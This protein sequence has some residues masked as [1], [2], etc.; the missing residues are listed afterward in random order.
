MIKDLNRYER[1]YLEKI[2]GL[3]QLKSFI[4]TDD[5]TD[6]LIINAAKDKNS[7]AYKYFEDN[8]EGPD[9]KSS[10]QE[11]NA[12]WHT[13]SDSKDK[14][15]PFYL[16]QER[17][18]M[19]NRSKAVL[20]YLRNNGYDY[21]IARDRNDGQITAK[22]TGKNLEMRLLDTDSNAM[23]GGTRVYRDGDVVR[24][25]QNKGENY[26]VTADM[27]VDLLKYSMGEPVLRKQ[28]VTNSAYDIDRTPAKA[29]RS[30]N[31][32]AGSFDFNGKDS[33]TYYTTNNTF[34]TLYMQAPPMAATADR[35]RWDGRIEIMVETPATGGKT[36]PRTFDADTAESFIEDSREA[37]INNLTG[38]LKL[39]A[40]DAL[41]RSK[42]NG[43]YEGMPEFSLDNE[44]ITNMQENYYR[45]RLKI[46]R[47]HSGDEQ[48]IRLGE[49]NAA[50]KKNIEATFGDADLR[51][52]N[53][54]N[55]ATFMNN[56]NTI[57]NE[58]DLLSALKT[59]QKTKH[60]TGQD[61]SYEITES[62]PDDF[63][64]NNF[65]N[66]LVEYNSDTARNI[67][68][69]SKNFKELPE[70]WQK[71][72]NTV[73]TSLE[74][75]GI[76]PQSIAVDDQGVIHYEGDYRRGIKN[77]KTEKVIGNIGQVFEPDSRKL[78]EKGEP[79]LKEGLIETK[80]ASGNNYYIAPGY[81]A[82]VVPPTDNDDKRTYVE[83]TRCRGYMQ[84]MTSNI[85]Q[86]INNDIIS[87]A[88]QKNDT[89]IVTLDNA[90]ALNNTYKHLYDE[91]LPLDFEEKMAQTGKD[92]DMIKAIIQTELGT[93]RYDSV[94][95]T[96]TNMLA[97]A[98]VINDE[99]DDPHKKYESK[100]GT[101]DLIADNT[102]AVLAKMD[103][104]A[105][106]H[107]FDKMATGTGT[108]QGIKVYLTSDAKV[109]D[110]GSITPGKSTKCPLMEH[111]DFRYAEYNSRDRVVMS[112]SNA[113]TQSSTARNIGTAHMSLGGFTQDDAFVIS[114]S[115]AEENVIRGKSGE[116][117]PLTIGDK[118]CD[119]SGNKGV[120]SYIGDPN[121]DE[122]YYKHTEITDNMSDDE[123]KKVQRD[124]DA[125]D[126]YKRIDDLFKANSDLQVIGAPYTPPSRFNGG[127]AR[128][129]IESQSWAKESG[130]ET[131]LN[132][133]GKAYP[134]SIGYVN[135]IV[136]D[137]P[138][139]EKTHNYRNKF[140]E[141]EESENSES[142]EEVDSTESI[143][144]R[145]SSGQ[146][147]GALAEL[148]AYDVIREIYSQNTE[149]TIKA[150]E[151]IIPMGYDISQTG[152][153]HKGYEPH[154]TG[155]DENNQPVYEVRQEIS[156][157]EAFNRCQSEIKS[158]M[159][160]NNKSFKQEFIDSL[161]AE[162]GFMK[163][164]FPIKMASGE[165][166]PA[167]KDENGNE[168]N[169]YLL[170]VMA[171]K[172][173]SNRETV[174]NRLT[175]HEY[176]ADYNR[177]WMA[178]GKYLNEKYNRQDDA[179]AMECMR[180]VQR[181]YDSM[182]ASIEDRYLD[183]KHNVWKDDVMRKQL[184]NTAT[185]VISP[186]PTLDL[187][188]IRMTAIMA[189][190]LGIDKDKDKQAVVWRD[191]VLSGGGVRMFDVQVIETR[192]DHA[193]YDPK[194]PMNG[195]VGI[196]MNPSSA[197]SFE[198]D[199]DGDS[200]GLYG[201]QTTK[202]K[203]NARETLSM[204]AN[205]L[206]KE[207]VV[208]GGD[209]KEIHPAYFQDGLDV[210]AG[211]YT[212]ESIGNRMNDAVRLANT[213]KDGTQKQEAFDK[214][215]DAM[216][217]A[218]KA[219]FG[220][221]IINYS[222]SKSYFE[223]LIPMT[224]SGAKGS[225]SK[226]ETYGKYFGA[227]VT[228]SDEGKLQDNFADKGKP[229][230]TDDE[231]QAAFSATHA[232]AVL[233]G[234]AGKSLQHGIMAGKNAP[235]GD[236]EVTYAAAAN[237]LTHPV[238]QSTMQLKHDDAETITRKINLISNI[239]PALWSGKMVEKS[240]DK[241]WQVKQDM[242]GK[243][244]NGFPTD[245]I[246]TPEEWKKSFNDFYT[247]KAGLGV[248]KPNPE[249]VD[250]MAKLLTRDGRIF[251]FDPQRKSMP[252]EK[253]LDSL[254][255]EASLE[256]LDRFAK[257]KRNLFEGSINELMAP[258][259]IADNIEI[260]KG[261]SDKTMKPL[262]AK[263]TQA[264]VSNAP[265]VD[266]VAVALKNMP[267]NE[268]K[269]ISPVK[270]EWERS[271]GSVAHR[272][273]KSLT[274]NQF[275]QT[276]MHLA[277]LSLQYKDEGSLTGDKAKAEMTRID[278][279]FYSNVQKQMKE[280]K[281]LSD[282]KKREYNNNIAQRTADYREL[283]AFSDAKHILREQQKVQVD[284]M[285]ATLDERTAKQQA[286]AFKPVM[287][288]NVE[289]KPAQTSD[290]QSM[291]TNKSKYDATKPYGG[292]EK[293][294]FHKAAQEVAHDIN[295]P[296]DDC[297]VIRDMMRHEKKISLLSHKNLDDPTFIA[298]YAQAETNN[299][300]DKSGKL[301]LTP[302]CKAYNFY[303]KQMQQTAE[304]TDNLS[305]GRMLYEKAMMTSNVKKMSEQESEF[306]RG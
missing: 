208:P 100:K 50:F 134:G 291:D 166:T 275:K 225:P 126:A 270:D 181:N 216:H 252:N 95:K 120:I 153:L 268:V 56:E 209:N 29:D 9:I 84:E 279:E 81:T 116:L 160:L 274:D 122:S 283:S 138:V 21:N 74:S 88:K 295:A 89:G 117:R 188:Q 236:N 99:A 249:Y 24:F 101:Y 52:I 44:F 127:T 255:Y 213:A 97:E 224:L 108:N 215:N 6:E 159:T 205:F 266:A 140:S 79:N 267:A 111:S 49:H 263:D 20:S 129:M 53:P 106:E 185:A 143:G 260:S 33:K 115:F 41:A 86:T 83:R 107:Y 151:L 214:F 92:K 233:T 229:F 228:I 93:V 150:R 130:K 211:K 161:S 125:K 201:L 22:L 288:A 64:L 222:D 31:E 257:Q 265:S 18:A 303:K 112:V 109:N 298:F 77:N 302:A 2:S 218:H 11:L 182:A 250:Q 269:I 226:L 306:Q 51:T 148:G 139:D 70:F 144:G 37:A 38:R 26:H 75:A 272:N 162:G 119:H 105:L 27:A 96:G 133:D 230:V 23:Y 40:V 17:W 3:S 171:G 55:V 219:A 251:G 76:N 87:I 223:S 246:P 145:K 132:V 289:T 277:S 34:S 28:R 281:A 297:Q 238:T 137:M 191:P 186:D 207:I 8:Y 69:V 14:D 296:G 114:K 221:D 248:D 245:H 227:E 61:R 91:K 242:P 256:K 264:C 30:V 123:K 206:N 10:K 179:K 287:Q 94:Y 178:A 12:K 240:P 142:F 66:K 237:A 103:G 173:R 65:K 16:S 304:S 192:P 220:Q 254:A 67:S 165:W 290:T 176:T 39:D 258:K 278:S 58:N 244:Q 42:A 196:T 57:D 276:A 261:K 19:I 1:A 282:D 203:K 62:S 286:G 155:V 280:Y 72:G 104:Q 164:P 98:K 36:L 197:T 124:N 172:Y 212:D 293:S 239:A 158:G 113:L 68:P 156:V 90:S 135:W 5:Y 152:E 7:A 234:V 146:L 85:R 198:G 253:A 300:R 63:Y 195:M 45:D 187:N 217:D 167:A 46:Y 47:E 121:R 80:F 136:T 147:V 157:T 299:I 235:E 15:S 4:P 243:G 118:I 174:D 184:S 305:K 247:D 59:L 241:T 168:T 71:I 199:F 284:V 210:A 32:L 154:I 204:T 294:D 141:P 149:S 60:G 271:D 82:Y 131:T 190:T 175:M 301:I 110:D 285:Q 231:I 163:L 194:N 35:K 262:N 128:E 200:V 183:G 180:D 13:E 189:E 169:E 43:E 259:V 273:Y 202:A 25:K 177:I 78:D 292:L 170:P 48:A 232:K 54:V 193:G 102:H 73:H